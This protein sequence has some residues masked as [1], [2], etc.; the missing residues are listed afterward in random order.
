ME[1]CEFCL[2]Q[3]KT[4]SGLKTHLR[5]CKEKPNEEKIVEKIL[6]S[7]RPE[8]TGMVTDALREQ[9]PDIIEKIVLEEIAKI[10]KFMSES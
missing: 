10:K 9:L 3:F 2:R 4:S 8:I 6:D 5:S 1:E 7:I